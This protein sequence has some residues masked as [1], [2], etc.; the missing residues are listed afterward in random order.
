MDSLAETARSRLAAQDRRIRSGT[1]L[2]CCKRVHRGS[3]ILKATAV[4]AEKALI[5]DVT[6]QKHVLSTWGPWG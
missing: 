3:M 4:G 1:V 6:P 2:D 5:C